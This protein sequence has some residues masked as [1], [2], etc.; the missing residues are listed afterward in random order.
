MRKKIDVAIVNRSFWPQ[1]QVIGEGLLRFSE[2]VAEH[3]SVCVITQAKGDL[4]AE[5]AREGRAKGVQIRSCK[6][7]T[8][9][10]SNLFKRI[11]ESI[12]FMLWTFISLVR[13]KPAN[14]YVSTNPPVLVPFVVAIYCKFFNTRYVYHLQDIH[15]EAAN[16]VVPINKL[17]F[18]LLKSID[19]YTLRHASMIVTLTEEMK[20]FIKERSKTLKPIH[21]LDNPAFDVNPIPMAERTEDIVFCGNAGRLQRIP[22]ILQ[23]IETYLKQGGSLRFTFAGGGK[24]IS[25]I[26]KLANSYNEVTYLGVLPATTA[27]EV[28]NQHKWALLPIDDEVTKYAFPSKTSGYALSGTGVLAV[29]GK[30]TAVADWVSGHNIGIICEA[31][32]E[33]LINCFFN[34]EKTTHTEFPIS[35]ELR[36]K[37][38]LDYFAKE[39]SQIITSGFFKE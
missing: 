5:L 26:E 21:I 29:C 14:V 27:A 31:N 13:A 16:I 24:Y 36:E 28:V 30:N 37:L 7:Y 11:F 12:F 1:S 10:A 22:L 20:S 17:L 34:I 3:H 9:S 6:A 35:P 39:L 32:H 33:A 18:R 19:N 2:K 15:P 38:Q 25:E 23:A 4:G 8:T